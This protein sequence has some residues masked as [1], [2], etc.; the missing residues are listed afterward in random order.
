M[1][2]RQSVKTTIYFLFLF[3]NNH[4]D[5]N[6]LGTK[7]NIHSMPSFAIWKFS[8]NKDP[9]SSHS[10]T[11]TEPK[12]QK[13]WIDKVL[14]LM[15]VPTD[16]NIRTNCLK[17]PSWIGIIQNYENKD[18]ANEIVQYTYKHFSSSIIIYTHM[19]FQA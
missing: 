1:P 14:K 5:C 19:E 11:K 6:I 8:H 2:S 17:D 4:E 16:R 7:N 3:L 9:L 13:A 12:Y 10:S 15:N 18:L